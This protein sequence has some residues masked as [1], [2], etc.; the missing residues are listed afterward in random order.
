MKIIA[1]KDKEGG[2]TIFH[3]DFPSVITEVETL[4]VAQD[5]LLKVFN[6]IIINSDVEVKEIRDL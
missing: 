4:E 2:Y 5:S 6:D 3:A 1:I